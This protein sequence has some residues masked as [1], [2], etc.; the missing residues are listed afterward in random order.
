MNDKFQGPVVVFSPN[1]FSLYTLCVTAELHQRGV[2]VAGIVVRKLIN[3]ERFIDEF[4]RDRFK[5]LRKI[6]NK[7]VL[8][9]RAFEKDDE[10]TI[11]ARK[12]ELGIPYGNVDELGADLEIPVVYCK[13]LNDS[14]V[15]EFLGETHPEVVAFTG[16]GLIGEK[17]LKK[18][19][20]GVLNC[21]MGVLPE[22]RGMDVVE[23]P[24]LRGD[25]DKI[26]LTVHFMDEGIDTGDILTIQ[27]I[28]PRPNDSISKLRKRMK[29][30]MCELLVDTCINYLRG[31]V[32]RKP[33]QECEGKQYFRVHSTMKRIAERK[34]RDHTKSL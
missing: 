21:H 22:Y 6:W 15:H 11:A 28:D 23:W 5:L 16:G 1:R 8:R 27:K 26:G 18:S 9:E 13:T 2:D 20:S 17:T 4:R 7:A 31:E 3:P 33:Q 34:Y 32:A 10:N 19:G 14:D 30:A 29:P 12:E 24:I 25:F